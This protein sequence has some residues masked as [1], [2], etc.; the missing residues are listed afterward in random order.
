MAALTTT[1]GDGDTPVKGGKS[2]E[3][4]TEG[5]AFEFFPPTGCGVRHAWV[6][7]RS[8]PSNPIICQ[9]SPQQHK[10]TRGDSSFRPRRSFAAPTSEARERF[11]RNRPSLPY[12]WA[13]PE[14]EEGFLLPRE[15]IISKSPP[16]ARPRPSLPT[17]IEE[18]PQDQQQQRWV[19]TQ[20]DDICPCRHCWCWPKIKVV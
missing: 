11:F 10:W 14:A 9:C 8:S 15:P 13:P 19:F 18:E 1:D 2:S 16:A 3:A 17:V 20:S 4:E 7:R 12:L 5:E 6:L